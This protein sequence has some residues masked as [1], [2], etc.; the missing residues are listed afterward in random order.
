MGSQWGRS[1]SRPLEEG[2]LFLGRE[3]FSQISFFLGFTRSEVKVAQSCPTL[4]YLMDCILQAR[5][6]DA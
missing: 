1:P 2:K 4:C 3:S 5:I 6:L